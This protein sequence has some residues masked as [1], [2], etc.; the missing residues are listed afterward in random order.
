[1]SIRIGEPIET[2]GLALSERDALI[3]RTRERI[4]ALLAEGPVV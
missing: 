4:E 2:A 3:A 1:V